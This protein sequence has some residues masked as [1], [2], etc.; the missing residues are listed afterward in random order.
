M[1][2]NKLLTILLLIGVLCL[3]INAVAAADNLT[4]K[5]MVGTDDSN[6]MVE[7]NDVH[8]ETHEASVNDVKNSKLSNNKLGASNEEVLGAGEDPLYYLWYYT[9]YADGEYDLT[10]DYKYT[11]GRWDDDPAMDM[12]IQFNKPLIVNGHGHTIDG[13]GVKNLLLVTGSNIIFM[14]IKFINGHDTSDGPIHI[15]GDNVYFFNCSFIDNDGAS[16]G[17]INW[18]GKDGGLTDCTFKSNSATSNG[19]ALY[20]GN[21]VEI[22]NCEFIENTARFFG[23]AVYV[24]DSITDQLIAESTFTN[25]S[26]AH[27]GAVYLGGK[28]GDI[29]NSKFNENHAEREGGAV[30]VKGDDCIIDNTELHANEAEYGGAVYWKGDDGKLIF[31]MHIDENKASVGGAVYWEGEN[32]NIYQS[33]LHNNHASSGGGLYLNAANKIE[34]SH[35]DSNDAE[36]GAGIYVSYK[37]D[38]VEVDHTNFGQNRARSTGGAIYWDAPNGIVNNSVFFNNWVD[39]NPGSA[40]GG[41]IYC[42]GDNA[43]INNSKFTWNMAFSQGSYADGGALNIKDHNVIVENCEFENNIAGSNGGAI[44]WEGDH[45]VV[46]NSTFKGN[47]ASVE[48]GAINGIGENLLI[49]ESTFIKNN[50]LY[51]VGGA[52]ALDAYGTVDNSTFIENFAYKGGAIHWIDEGYCII[53]N[54]VFYKNHAIYAGGA[55]SCDYYYFHADKFIQNTEFVNNSCVNYGGAVASLDTEMDNCTFINNSANMGGAVHSYDSKIN[56]SKFSNNNA[57][58]GNDIYHSGTLDL[59]NIEVPKE[60]IVFVPSELAE[61]VKYNIG[62]S[63]RLMNNSYIGM[64]FERNSLLPKYGSYDE[65]LHALIN[66]LTGESIVEY[67]KIL[68]YDSFNSMDDVYSHE[69]DNYTL[70]PEGWE[71]RPESEDKSNWVPISRTDYYSRVVHIF[72][73]CDFRKSVHP[74]VKRILELYDNGF[75]VNQDQTK[76]VNG[77]TILYH[78]STLISPASQSLFLFLIQKPNM[79][80]NK[81]YLNKTVTVYV[82]DTV[83][84]NITVNNTGKGP[85]INVTVNEKYNPKELQYV[86][87]SDSSKWIKDGD[88]FR[89]NGTIGIG[90]NATLTVWF[91]TLASGNL[92]NTV[93]A[94]SKGVNGT[95]ANNTTTVYRH[96]LSVKKISLTPIVKIG[97]ITSFKIVV[98]NT[99]DCKLGDIFVKENDYDGLI[100]K[101]YKGGKWTKKGDTFY[102]DGV[103]NPGE[104]CEFTVFFKTTKVGD[105]INTVIAGS[106][107]T[108]NETTHN[109]TKVIENKTPKTPVNKTNKTVP[110]KP[111]VKTD[112]MRPTGNPIVALLAVLFIACGTSIRKFKK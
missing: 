67:L 54:S 69:G 104:S 35:F 49:N 41:A 111:P 89:Y 19:G 26:A 16:G 47:N 96:S 85:L 64:C 13:G 57:R 39:A 14:D 91:K 29:A 11:P 68:I 102:F 17:A 23:G 50:A 66:V 6:L 20:V 7:K 110:K 108:D 77:S 10:H 58:Y 99:G 12:G 94:A 38:G 71:G 75:R 37:A 31:S 101:S 59:I 15:Y 63:T 90:K 34:H 76:E 72:S 53:N 70:Y 42:D 82:H 84:F 22:Q 79:T 30:Y 52:L 86:R 56:S 24:P 106:N 1:K 95:T 40:K 51:Y 60:N 97:E 83:A 98:T 73:D 46:Y 3:C 27:G 87:H 88:V 81:T 28:K 45:G 65:S 2:F 74:E 92:L 18:Q 32:G 43:L 62:N 103:L 44:H 9:Y 107:F 78:F 48:G 112:I 100:F 33:R 25:N 93:V 109:K 8:E 21:P 36:S 80:V 5:S 4:E 61:I 105:F 55:V